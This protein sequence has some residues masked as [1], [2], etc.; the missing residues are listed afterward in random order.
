MRGHGRQQPPPGGRGRHASG[1]R[2][3]SMTAGGLGPGVDPD[4]VYRLAV[5]HA[6]DLIVVVDA[7]GRI[8]YASPSYLTMLGY[9]PS[10]LPGRHAL[11][12]VHPRDMRAAASAVAASL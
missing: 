11:S 5:E 3:G 2:G 6:R 1:L 12:F 10:D 4:E 9:E 7:E 8:V